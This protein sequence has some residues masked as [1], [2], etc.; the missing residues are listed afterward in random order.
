MRCLVPAK[1]P[2]PSMAGM[3]RGVKGAG[4]ASYPMAP[5]DRW[6][7]D[8]DYEARGGNVVKMTPDEFLE[9]AAPLKMDD[10][11]RENID[12][13]KRHIQEGRELDPLTLYGDKSSVRN[14]D[15]RHRAI[16]A[17]E[18]GMLEVPVLDFRQPTPAPT[19][20][21]ALKGKK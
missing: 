12:D 13:L 17:K 9:N 2:M 21:D 1:E 14:S 7:A 4:K 18:L 16:A 6:Y 15:G 8:A 11:A 3:V 20:S 10:V 19:M 5:R